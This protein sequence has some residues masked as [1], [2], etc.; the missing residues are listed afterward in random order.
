MPGGWIRAL[1]P[2]NSVETLMDTGLRYPQGPIR[3]AV[4][5][6]DVYFI[7]TEGTIKKLSYS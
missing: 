3:M 4:W 7:S 5:E 6:G 2:N 1:L